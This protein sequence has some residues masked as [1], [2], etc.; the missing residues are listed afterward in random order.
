M[1]GDQPK[2]CISE[3]SQD[4]E[5]SP[6]DMRRLAITQ[7]S[8]KDHQ[9]MLMWK[10]LNEKNSC[11]RKNDNDRLIEIYLPYM[12]L[13]KWMREVLFNAPPDTHTHAPAT[14][15]KLWLNQQNWCGIDG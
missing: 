8:A 15:T 12:N 10:I 4:T 5:K 3:I 9:L 1:N 11:N 14:T 2:Y 6:G 7:T 13:K